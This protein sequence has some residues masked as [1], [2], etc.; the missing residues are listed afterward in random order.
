MDAVQ[1][2]VPAA[3]LTLQGWEKEMV[4]CWWSCQ[5]SRGVTG[6]ASP[7]QLKNGGRDLNL[8]P[9]A[10][11]TH[12]SLEERLFTRSWHGHPLVPRNSQALLSAAV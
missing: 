2:A 9:W 5:I 4:P 3:V 1:P 8:L 7:Q 12:F 10:R 6:S 11:G